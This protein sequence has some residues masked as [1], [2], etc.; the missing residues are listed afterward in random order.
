MYTN[1]CPTDDDITSNQNRI[2]EHFKQEIELKTSN[3]TLAGLIKNLNIISHL[4]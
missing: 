3:M 1:I 2:I 4:I